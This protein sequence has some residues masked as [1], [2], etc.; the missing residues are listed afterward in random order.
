MEIVYLINY[1]PWFGTHTGYERLPSHVE[2]ADVRIRL[3]RPPPGW[4]PYALGK[5][6]SLLRGHGQQPQ[7]E[8][9]SRIQAEWALRTDKRRLAHLLY[10][11]RH[12]CFWKDAPFSVRKRTVLTLHQ[13]P[14]VW[15]AVETKSLSFYQHLIVLWQKDVDWFQSHLGQGVVSFIHHGVDIDFFSPANPAPAPGA[16]IRLLYAGVHLRN[17]P[18]L[19]RVIR[20]LSQRRTDI[21]FD[22]LVPVARRGHPALAELQNNKQVTWH[23][24]LDDEQLRDLYRQAYLMVLPMDDSGANTAIIEAI[25]CGLPIVSTDVGGIRDYGGGTVFPVV[26]NNDDDAMI[27]LIED[28][29]TRPALRDEVSAR[30]RSF[31][32]TKL[33]WPLI[34]QKHLD[35]YRTVME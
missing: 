27:G 26:D 23:A 4:L 34:V 15:N 19:G 9:F 5:M 17:L 10:G 14:S 24:N 21:Q 18:M 30:C 29:L 2:K 28:Y 8:A 11:E 32:E 35:V 1:I 16:K 20:I 22:L 13:P 33:A 6:A 25:S 7:N 12:L 31:A 3:F